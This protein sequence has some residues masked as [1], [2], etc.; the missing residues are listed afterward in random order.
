M[1]VVAD[2]ACNNKVLRMPA[3]RVAH[4]GMAVT[5]GD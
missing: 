4:R 1:K 3:C 2:K 5:T